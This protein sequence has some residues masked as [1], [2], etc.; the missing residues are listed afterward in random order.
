MA[1]ERDYSGI[2]VAVAPDSYKGCLT[3]QEV[4]RCMAL[5]VRA[6]LPGVTVVECPMA[7]GGEGTA[8]IIAEALGPERVECEAAD[9][10]GRAIRGCYYRKGDLAVMD[11]ATATGIGLLRREEYA[12]MDADSAGTG[13][14]LRKALEDGCRMIYAGLGGSAT[15]DGGTG[16]ARVFGVR[17]LKEDNTEARRLCDVRSADFSE[18]ICFPPETEI[19]LI[20]DVDAPLT[21][22]RGAAAVFG[23]Q[24]GADRD[25]VALLDASLGRLALLTGG[26]AAEAGAG[27]AGGIGFMIEQLARRSGARCRM[28]GGAESVMEITG[29]DSRAEGAALILTGEGRSDAQTL[30]GKAPVAVLRHG[31]AAGAKVALLAG[32]VDNRAAL[33]DAGFSVI[34]SIHPPGYN[35]AESLRPDVTR[36]HLY[37]AAYT[38]ARELIAGGDVS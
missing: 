17:F 27:A 3:A 22:P 32:S 8:E 15:V 12:P 13:M 26:D 37:E 35:P 10:L 14:I 23:P 38:V 5:G 9:P 31:R 34:R 2:K 4:A 18:M 29:F 24:K 19:G 36:R 28:L 11:V 33:L 1:S 20:S 25:E 21:G 16:L 7:D 6:A 30:M